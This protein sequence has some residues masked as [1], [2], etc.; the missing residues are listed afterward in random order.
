MQA[1]SNGGADARCRGRAE[2]E[3]MGHGCQVEWEIYGAQGAGGG[4]GWRLETHQKR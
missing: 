3:S 4:W 1:P 2:L